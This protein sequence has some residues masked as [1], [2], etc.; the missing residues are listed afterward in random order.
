MSDWLLTLKS[1]VVRKAMILGALVFASNI[2]LLIT[3]LGVIAKLEYSLGREQEA[4]QIVACVSQFLAATQFATFALI[5]RTR[6]EAKTED[7]Y[8]AVFGRLPRIFAELKQSLKNRPEDE[9][10]VEALSEALDE[11]ITLVHKV[12]VSYWKQYSPARKMAH[13][14]Y[15]SDLIRVNNSIGDLLTAIDDKYSPLETAEDVGSNLITI[16]SVYTIFLLALVLNSGMTLGCLLMVVSALFRRIKT[17]SSNTINIGLAKH[18]ELPEV[19]QDE[20]GSIEDELRELAY[21]L[22]SA[23]S[24]EAMVLEHAADFVCLLDQ[25]AIVLSVTEPSAKLLGYPVGDLVGR[26][27]NSI[28]EP[29]DAQALVDAI[30]SL[31]EIDSSVSFESRVVLRSGEKRDFS[32]RAKL[33]HDKTIVCDANDIS[34]KKI[35]SDKIRESEGHFRTILNSLPLMVVGLSQSGQ[36]TSINDYGLSLSGYSEEE[37]LGKSIESM[38]TTTAITN[39]ITKITSTTAIVEGQGAS[40]QE[41]LLTQRLLLRDG[42][43][44]AVELV[45]SNYA[46]EGQSDKKS[47]A[48]V[49]DVSV[50]EQIES[51]KRDFVNMIGHDLRSPLMSL[52]ATLSYI[53]KATSLA[54]VAEAEQIFVELIAVT[55]DFLYLGKLEAG[56]EELEICPTPFSAFFDCLLQVVTSFDQAK[57]LAFGFSTRSSINCDALKIIKPDHDFSLSVDRDCLSQCLAHLL[58]ILCSAGS[59]KSQYIL[60]FRYKPYELEVFIVGSSLTL[61]SSTLASLSQGYVSFSQASGDLRSGLS[62]G[63]AIAILA[64]HGCSLKQYQDNKQQGF[65]FVM[66]VLAK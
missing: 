29:N 49:R 4:R 27:L 12:E 34:E 65:H 52:S 58:R 31:K 41:Q 51:A 9:H 37:L 59:D 62:L 21:Q 56:E 66:P 33:S 55:T 18:S 2:A 17:I 64:R 39:T 16:G 61:A 36:I 20:L 23:K 63:L 7:Q 47:M 5:E 38:F 26:R 13:A 54:A 1:S 8:S 32:F 11:E 57:Q 24:R 6:T 22:S 53:S 30:K 48:F 43:Y 14:Q 44:L 42:S 45:L 35:L 19:A 28:V 3:F 40:K 50:R 60:D 15:C 25:K 10:Q 46:E